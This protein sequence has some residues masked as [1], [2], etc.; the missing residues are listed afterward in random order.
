MSHIDS[1]A[2]DG[3]L[4]IRFLAPRMLDET[5]LDK[6]AQEMLAVIEKTSDEKVILDFAPVQFMPSSMLGKLVMINKKCKEYKVKLK[7]SGL[8]PDIRE[9]FKISRLD[10]VFSIEKDE[11]A[12]RK[13]FLKRGLFG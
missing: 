11:P 9:V 3:V 8:S 5:Q 13:A 7:L 2:K 6:V 12:A 10:K 4:T 1:F